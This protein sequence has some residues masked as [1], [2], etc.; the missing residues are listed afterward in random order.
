MTEFLDAC[1]QA[2]RVQ[3][4]AI[5]ETL[6][7]T[8][9]VIEGLSLSESDIILT[10]CGDSYAVAHYGQWVFRRA[11][12]QAV[13]LSPTEV[14]RVYIDPDT[15]IIGITA[16]GRSLATIAALKHARN[17]GARTVV[18]TDDRRGRASENAD[19]VWVTRALVESYNISPSS[20]TTSAMA[21]LFKIGNTCSN[22]TLVPEQEDLSRL[23]EIGD[24]MIDWAEAEGK[25]IAEMLIR[26][27]PLY[28]VSDGPNYVAAQLGQMKFNEYSLLHSMVAL[29]EEFCHHW[30]LNLDEGDQV[31]LIT[32]DPVTDDDLRYLRVL[33]DTLKMS[34]YHSHADEKLG[35]GSDLGQAI[36]NTITLQMAAYYTVLRYSPEKTGW[37]QPNA[38]AFKIY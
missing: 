4:E 9:C 14:P 20:P 25:R 19:E 36:V 10:G 8:E 12:C 37:R 26:D 16:S 21:Y 6:E 24:A 28:L 5:R 38:N 31:V 34:V 35:L 29:R 15:V 11:G 7:S 23:R 27:R 3:G 30:N 32:D 17:R 2:I 33:K 13:A 18:L 1:Y 22:T